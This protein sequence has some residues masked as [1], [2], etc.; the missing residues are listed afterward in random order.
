M[1]PALRPLL[2]A[3][4]LA[5]LPLL[6]GLAVNTAAP[7]P[8]TASGAPTY[9]TRYCHN[10]ACLH[11][12]PANSLAYFQ[13]RPLYGLTVQT[14]SAGGKGAPYILANL[15]VFLVAIPVLLLRLTYAVLR[16]AHVI[17]RLQS[18]SPYA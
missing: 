1:L 3:V 17:R 8:P 18:T 16:D 7:H 11:A 10:H 4:L 13:L 9:C 2:L 5:L 14:L 15:L 12:T 6:F